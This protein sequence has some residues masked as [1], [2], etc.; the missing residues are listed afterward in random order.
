MRDDP[1]SLPPM[2]SANVGRSQDS[3][4]RIVPERGQFSENDVEAS[5]SES[6]RV[7]HERESRS[8]LANDASHL[9]P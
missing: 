4:L 1:D 6:W 3:P 9:P 2:R 8:N 7:F 5:T